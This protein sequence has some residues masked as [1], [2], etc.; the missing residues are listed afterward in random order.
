MSIKETFFNWF[1][2][3]SKTTQKQYEV[4]LSEARTNY[5]YKKYAMQ[6]C[7]NWIANSISLCDFRTYE[8]SKRHKGHNWWKLNYEPN[9]NQN[10]VDFWYQV[11]SRAVEDDGALIIQTRE[12][13]FVVADSFIVEEKA[14]VE[15]IYR[16]VMLP[17]NYLDSRTYRES[18]VI[19]IKLNNSKIE[20]LLDSIYS[21][22]GKLLAGTM[23][24]YNRSNA[25]K[26][27]LEIDTTF[28]QLHQTIDPDTGE[29]EAD[30]ILDDIFEN[31]FK[32][33]LS[34][35]DAVMPMEKGLTVTTPIQTPGNTKSGA[36]TTRD[37]TE[38]FQDFINIAADAFGIPRGLIKGDVADVEAMRDNYVNFCVRPFVNEIESEFNRKI[39]GQ[40]DVSN[41]TKLVIRT[42]SIMIHTLIKSASDAEA[43]FR[44]GGINQDG[45]LEMTGEE[46]L[47]TKESTA[48]YVTKNYAEQSELKGGE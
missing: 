28:N 25:M 34:D 19:R 18:E 26:L 5:I 2:T 33:F 40:K 12:G 29:V 16:S 39:Y 30:T 3:P 17:G 13:D 38:V 23:R 20:K 14:F 10:N 36:S 8:N 42:Q 44:V 27:I 22:Y 46:P 48:Y 47:N 1:I 43:L 9:K 37:I 35:A 45:I 4:M 11:V 31:R 32:S 24:N 6:I 41:G 15:N 7:I 21:D